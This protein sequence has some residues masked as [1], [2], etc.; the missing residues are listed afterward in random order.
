MKDYVKKGRKRV[1]PSN[2]TSSSGATS[3]RILSQE[4]KMDLENSLLYT[5]IDSARLPGLDRLVTNAK[6]RRMLDSLV[7][8]Y[9]HR[10]ALDCKGIP[11]RATVLIQG[12]SGTGK[13]LCASALARECGLKL[14]IVH[15]AS[16]FS[17]SENDSIEKLHRLFQ[18]IA[19]EK[20]L[21]LISDLSSSLDLAGSHRTAS[22]LVSLLRANRQYADS[23]VV[24]TSRR[25]YAKHEG[26]AKTF[27]IVITFTKPT[28]SEVER[29]F[30]IYLP[31]FPPE[32]INSRILATCEDMV[33][34]DVVRALVEARI[35]SEEAGTLVS[36]SQLMNI[37]V[38]NLHSI[39]FSF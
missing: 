35:D 3:V 5:E 29:L 24:V 4:G 6:N 31:G 20:A 11:R 2:C 15:T 27:D 12:Q 17:D 14:R 32:E 16:V 38:D 36:Q 25:G 26:F 22:A 19:S 9:A 37:F 33:H 23:L 21:Y 34:A 28:A 30:S 1:R 39:R 7:Y 18:T 13:D 10:E 8:E